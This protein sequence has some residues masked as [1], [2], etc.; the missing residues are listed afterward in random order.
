MKNKSKEIIDSEEW[1]L[2]QMKEELA[3]L[4][5]KWVKIPS[6]QKFINFL[7]YA[8]KEKEKHIKAL[9]DYKEKGKL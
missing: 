6:T 4:K 7:E 5:S 2:K 9:K 3:S 8:V 1:N